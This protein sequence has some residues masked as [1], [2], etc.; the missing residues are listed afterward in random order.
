MTIL[1]VIKTQHNTDAQI[2]IHVT[3]VKQM[4]V[5][6]LKWV[7]YIIFCVVYF[8]LCCIKPRSRMCVQ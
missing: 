7:N 6:A 5:I 3:H 8:G 2:G 1:T 4:Q